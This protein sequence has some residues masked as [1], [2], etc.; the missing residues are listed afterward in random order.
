MG[1]LNTFLRSLLGT[2]IW[3]LIV[4]ILYNP[5]KKSIQFPFLKQKKHD[6]QRHAYPWEINYVASFRKLMLFIRNIPCKQFFID[7]CYTYIF[8][9][10]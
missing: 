1:K 5:S 3:N 2:H 9:S 4:Q 8:F 7:L 10:H 6:Y